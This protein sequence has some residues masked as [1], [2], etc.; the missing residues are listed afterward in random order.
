MRICVRACVCV[1][2]GGGEGVCMCVCVCRVC[3]FMCVFACPCVC[4]CTCVCC[5]QATMNANDGLAIRWPPSRQ[6]TT[7]TLAFSK[8]QW[9]KP[10][11]P[12]S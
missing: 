10:D 4:V 6:T 3:V 9:Y 2:G 1:C 12:C 7:Q 11:G 5:P 8:T